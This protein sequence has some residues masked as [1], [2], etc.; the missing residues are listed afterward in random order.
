MENSFENLLVWQRS[1]RL[2]EK[3]YVLSHANTFD[4]DWDLGAQMR[5]AA[6]S[7]P[8][9]IAEGFEKGTLPDA[10]KFFYI[11]KGS[12]GELRTQCLLAGRIRY[13]SADEVKLLS[14]EA[15]DISR[16]IMGLIR[17]YQEREK[18]KG[19]SSRS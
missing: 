17:A 2:A 14:A 1:M 10:I 13:L 18:T 6:T 12:A 9:N 19:P 11:A 15:T 3:I 8:F 16:M 7:V 5:R 4:R